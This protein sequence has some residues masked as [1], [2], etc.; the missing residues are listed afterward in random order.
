[1]NS[2]HALEVSHLSYAYGTKTALEKVSF[3]VAKGECCIL[4]GPNGAGKSTLFSLITRLF[5]ARSGEIRIAGQ[6]GRAHV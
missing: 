2:Q 3:E 6:I 1:M 5:D 4:L